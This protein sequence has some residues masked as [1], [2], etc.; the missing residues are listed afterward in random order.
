M[1]RIAIAIILLMLTVSGRLNPL[2]SQSGLGS[3]NVLIF[4][5]NS[6]PIPHSVSVND[7]V[8]FSSDI[9]DVNGLHVDNDN[10]EI[11]LRYDDE[12]NPFQA[13][14]FRLIGVTNDSGM[15]KWIIPEE[16]RNHI[17]I[18]RAVKS[19]YAESYGNVLVN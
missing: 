2:R 5:K 8:L 19:G 11:Y 14:N 17:I 7:T 18:V 9:K 13:Y 10:V 16:A 15:L 1:K 6:Q 12:M 3:I 4:D